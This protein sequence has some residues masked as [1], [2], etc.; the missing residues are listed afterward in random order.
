MKKKRIIK[1]KKL[2]SQPACRKLKVNYKKGKSKMKMKSSKSSTI[3]LS[4]KWINLIQRLQEPI[5]LM[6][7]F[8]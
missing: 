8:D 1:T 6:N 7:G 5:D 2:N 4:K 3:E